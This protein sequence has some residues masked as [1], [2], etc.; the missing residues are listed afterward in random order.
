MNIVLIGM[1]GCGKSSVS[2]L[3]SVRTKRFVFSTDALIPYENQGDQIDTIL[4]KNNGDWHVFRELEYLVVKKIVN[5]D[6]L[7]IDTGGGVVVDLDEE[8][9]EVYSDRK[10]ALLKKRGL[11]IWLKED[12][13]VLLKK[14]RASAT[15]PPLSISEPIQKI[16]ERRLPFYKQAADVT[17][18]IGGTKRKKL[19][20][21]ICQLI[22][23]YPEKQ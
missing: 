22:K 13:S 21:Q 17:I 10:V 7:I 18:E 11:V 3:L 20:E 8:D 15:R 4:K 23:D 6:N 19:V 16:M 9:K 5:Q 14:A 12:I 2:R 1:R